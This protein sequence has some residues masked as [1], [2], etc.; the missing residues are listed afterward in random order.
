MEGSMALSDV[1]WTGVFRDEFGPQLSALVEVLEKRLLPAFEGIETEAQRISEDTWDRLMSRPATG[2]EDP[3]DFAEAAQEAGVE[4]FMLMDGIRQ[5]ILN[6][7]AVALYH[8][9][10][11]QMMLFHRKEVLHPAE[12]D[13][14]TLFALPV[15]KQR[16]RGF[17]IDMREFPSWPKVDELRLAANT[18]KHA[19][20]KS[21]RRLH[22]TRPEM[23]EHPRVAAFSSVQLD[24]PHVFQPLVGEGLYVSLRDIRD[25]H[26]HLV[27]FWEELTDAMQRA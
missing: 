23:F 25:Y 22:A 1:Y 26:A 15:L 17:G 2:D 20:G 10:E 18:V 7:F 6:M 19:E 12:E 13:D 21:A 3:G 16:L 24:N 5:G 8:A 9:F 27:Q 14:Q 4:H 11:Q